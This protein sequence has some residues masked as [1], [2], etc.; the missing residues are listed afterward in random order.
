MWPS[1]LTLLLAFGGFS[2]CAFL[3]HKK[4]RKEPLM[5]PLRAHCDMVIH[6]SYSRFFG[7]RLE[8]IGMGYYGFMIFAEA[9]VLSVTMFQTDV[10][11]YLLFFL[12][13]FAFLFS[14]YLIGIQAVVLRNWC[15]WCVVSAF[16]CATLFALSLVRVPGGVVETLAA[17]APAFVFLQWV[18][19]ALG[20]GGATISDFLFFRFLKD[21]R[22]SHGEAEILETLSQTIWLALAFLVLGTAGIFAAHPQA[23]FTFPRFFLEGWILIVLILNAFALHFLV[24]PHLTKISFGERHE[25]YA[26]ELRSIR[27]LAFA[28]GATSLVS[29][30]GTLVLHGVETISRSFFSLGMFYVAALL[31]AIVLSQWM[32][33]RL[34]HL[35]DGRH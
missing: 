33:Y 7:V 34:A 12:K 8:H 23:F 20:V 21:L 1:V 19:V 18:G 11:L 2:I 15:S 9:L 30:Y 32:E 29:W 4:N 10:L 17:H 35:L 3:S 22:I 28:L 13:T 27:R 6:S 31:A 14:L 25:H 5:C 26:G 24:A 16:F